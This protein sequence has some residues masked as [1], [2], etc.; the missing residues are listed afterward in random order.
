MKTCSM[1]YLEKELTEFEFRKERNSYRT[2][3]K[4]CRKPM[5]AKSLKN[6]KENNPDKVRAHRI[7]YD[8]SETWKIKNESYRE[9]YRKSEHW[10]EVL[11]AYK[12]TKKYDRMNKKHQ[13]TYLK[14]TD[15]N[16]LARCH[17]R[18]AA[19]RK[20][21]WSE[22]I[23]DRKNI[24]RNLFRELLEKQNYK[25][26]VSWKSLVNQEWILTYDIDHIIP[27]CKWWEHCKDNIRLLLPDVHAKL[28]Y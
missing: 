12:Q 21:F 7:T 17:K 15:V 6:W 20:H 25:C 11:K 19:A 18:L 27:F 22:N 4:E 23:I 3:C 13:Q 2:Q 9:K 16:F 8:Q 28:L 26:A 14:K 5:K 24:T 1:C 10:S